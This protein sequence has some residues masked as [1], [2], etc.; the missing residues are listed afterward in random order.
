MS[1]TTPPGWYPDPSVPSLERWW[2]GTAWTEHTRA[3][4][5]AGH[6]AEQLAGQSAGQPVGF[7]P[8]QPMPA[9]GPGQSAGR[10]KM[11]ALA[12][13]GVVLIAAIVTGVVV[14]GKDDTDGAEAKSGGTPTAPPSETGDEQPSDEPSDD[15]TPSASAS[16]DDP[17]VLVDQL[18]GVSLPIPDGWEKPE[19]TVGSELTMRTKDSYDCPATSGF[20]YHGTVTSGTAD[21]GSGDTAKEAAEKDI[22]DWAELA[23]GEGILDREPHGGITSTKK[24]QAGQ[25][26][27][28]GRTGYL[29]RWQVKTGKGPGG[30]VQSLAFPSTIGTESLII[31]RFAFDAGADGPPLSG[32]DEITKGIR[33]LGDE[34]AGTGGVGS[35]ISP[36]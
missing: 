12:V 30:Y 3:P 31:V 28:A 6:S 22:S 18:N 7:G 23:Y 9:S 20:C 25:V 4:Q 36:S 2:D 21:R 33:D 34:E 26:A 24:V 1:M 15:P 5:Q 8:A 14:L 11:I 32:M 17:S 35:S 13:A 29:V 27:V 10:G 16:A 19:H